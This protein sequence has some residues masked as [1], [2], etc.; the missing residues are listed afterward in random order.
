MNAKY[1]TRL[2]CLGFLA[3]AALFSLIQPAP[4]TD[5]QLASLAG[6]PAKTPE[7]E[8]KTFQLPPGFQIDLVA[9]EPQIVDPVA[10][11]FDEAG[12][13]FVA[14]MRGYPNG[15]IGRGNIHSGV[16]KLLEDRDGDGFYETSTVFVDGLGLP[17]SVMPYKQGLLIA[18]APDLIYCEDR[19]GDGKA[20]TRRKL[21]TGFGTDNIQQLLNGLQWGLDNWI[22]GCAG[23]N[24]G[25][26]QSVEKPDAP[27][28]VLQ[29]SRDPFSSRRS[30]AAWKRPREGGNTPW[31][32]TIGGT[33]SRTRIASILRQIVLPDH[34]LRLPISVL[35]VSPLSV[36]LD[37]PDHGEWLAGCSR[38]SGQCEAFSSASSAPVAGRTIPRCAPV[39]PQRSWSQVDLSRR[40]AVR[41]STRQIS[42]ST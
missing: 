40:L 2:L 19:D 24:G 1:V 21:Y 6:P 4:A 31:Q 3:T 42:V 10:M 23:S 30:P 13:L 20:D 11:A 35:A 33:G 17:T 37:I 26:V 16:V 22:Y 34:Y 5:D 36:T 39:C 25:S 14:E 18:V 12:R 38:I 9:S 29:R 27:P 15:G 41:S 7:E 8:K 32:P 28:V